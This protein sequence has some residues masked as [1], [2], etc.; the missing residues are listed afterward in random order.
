MPFTSEMTGASS[1]R[2]LEDSMSWTWTI[3]RV[4]DSL[5]PSPRAS[6]FSSA[7]L[8][9]SIDAATYAAFERRQEE[10]GVVKEYLTTAKV[11]DLGEETLNE[12][13]LDGSPDSYRGRRLDYLA[14]RPI[15]SP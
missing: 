14:R 3:S 6:A 2:E 5:R 7:F 9:L 13:K 15:W 1:V 11:T 12:M 4:A 10:I 8:K